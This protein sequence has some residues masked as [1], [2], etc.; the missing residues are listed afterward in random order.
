[1]AYKGPTLP[2]H[3]VDMD[4]EPLGPL[5]VAVQDTGGQWSLWPF[6]DADD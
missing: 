2:Q 5:M 1:V 4:G 6:G 3:V